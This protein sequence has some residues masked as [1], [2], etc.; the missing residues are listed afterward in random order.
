MTLSRELIDLF[1]Q[2]QSIGT[3][4]N[5]ERARSINFLDI[6]KLDKNFAL[7]CID[8]YYLTKSEDGR[9]MTAEILNL[10]FNIR[11]WNGFLF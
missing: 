5:I 7:I 8:L 11:K 3:K 9:R 10:I 6:V 2:G 4:A 1:V